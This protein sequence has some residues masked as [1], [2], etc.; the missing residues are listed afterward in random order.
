MIAFLTTVGMA[1]LVSA[2]ITLWAHYSTIREMD[3]INAFSSEIDT[4]HAD[5]LQQLKQ[6]EKMQAAILEE[7]T[8]R[9]RA[10]T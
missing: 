3:R 7:L 9:A 5:L 8:K 1:C 2:L 10:A 4:W 6:T